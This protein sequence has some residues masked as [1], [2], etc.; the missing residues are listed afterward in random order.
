MELT[1]CPHWSRK[2]LGPRTSNT[3]N[4]PN[5]SFPLACSLKGALHFTLLALGVYWMVTI[6]AERKKRG[7]GSLR[8]LEVGKLKNEV[9]FSAVNI[10]PETCPWEAGFLRP[11]ISPHFSP[12]QQLPW[13]QCVRT[14]NCIGLLLFK[15]D[16]TKPCIWRLHLSSC[17]LLGF[18][19]FCLPL[20][21]E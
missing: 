21:A 18:N 14:S 19:P 17:S 5:N 20:N 1:A 7:Q 9:F 15:P 12:G 16:L 10:M 8:D 13:Q 2:S 3:T 6:I 11:H 4:S